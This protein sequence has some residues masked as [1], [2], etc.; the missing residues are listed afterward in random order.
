MAVDRH[1]LPPTSRHGADGVSVPKNCSVGAKQ[2]TAPP[3]R[4]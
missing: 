1:I 4:A 3:Q 2:I